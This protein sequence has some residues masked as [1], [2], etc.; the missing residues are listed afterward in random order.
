VG[1]GKIALLEAIRRTGSLSQGARDLRMS[2]RRAW[3]LLASLNGSFR[4]A[5]AVTARG[6]R[7][8]GGVRLTRFGLALIGQYRAFEEDTQARAL[9]AFRRIAGKARRGRRAAAVRPRSP[10]SR[11]VPERGSSHHGR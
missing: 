3:Q 6:G 8:G 7:N 10:S 2:Y 5:V 4:E 1:P 9:K 11:S